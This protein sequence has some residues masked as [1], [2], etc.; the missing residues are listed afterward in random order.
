MNLVTQPNNQI[1]AMNIQAFCPELDFGINLSVDLGFEPDNGPSTP[2]NL[3]TDLYD[4]LCVNIASDFVIDHS[5]GTSFVNK[6]YSVNFENESVS[7]S[8]FVPSRIWYNYSP[9]MLYESLIDSSP[10]PNLGY[11]SISGYS[12]EGSKRCEASGL[13]DCITDAY[14]NSILAT[15]S[16]LLP[17]WTCIDFIFSMTIHRFNT[18]ICLLFTNMIF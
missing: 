18:A 17:L 5:I 13:L 9:Y 6:D 15:L 8:K 14:Y 10:A 16:T 7:W 12:I 4:G 2:E 1:I 3:G 11:C